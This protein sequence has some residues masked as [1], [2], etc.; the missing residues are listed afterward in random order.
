M[1][2]IFR[3]LVAVVLGIAWPVLFLPSPTVQLTLVNGGCAT[4]TCVAHAALHPTSKTSKET[5]ALAG[6]STGSGAPGSTATRPSS[7]TE[8]NDTDDTPSTADTDDAT[9][10]PADSPKP[11]PTSNSKP[12]PSPSS[13]PK[14]SPISQPSST[15]PPPSTPPPSGSACPSPGAFP[16]GTFA[17]AFVG[18]ATRTFSQQYI[19]SIGSYVETCY[20]AGSSAPSSGA[21]GGAQA[22]LPLASGA[23]D[24]ATLTYQIRF[25]VGFSWVKG[26]K[27][28][29]LC[30]AQCWTGSSNGPGGWAGRFMWRAG[31]AGEVLISDA[32]TTGYGTDLGLGNWY[33]QADGQWHTLTEH[34]HMNTPGQADGFID[35]TYNGSLVGHFTGITFRTDTATHVDGLMF[36]T[37]FGGHDSTW[38]PSSPQRI[39]FA[40]FTVS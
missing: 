37:F 14:P 40:G 38:A 33:Y 34:V 13:N 28:P 6:T 39:D 4:V 15:P 9:A 5:T 21:P 23:P 18:P 7:S 11:S 20:P 29:G 1:M 36:S 12:G 24:D 19:T 25:P 17:P 10:D 35:V 3:R 32:T 2:S 22:K 27:L 8:P 31:G 26:G 16:V 30:G